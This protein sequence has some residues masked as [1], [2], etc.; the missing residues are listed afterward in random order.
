MHVSCICCVHDGS[1]C[2]LKGEGSSIQKINT[3]MPQ[4]LLPLEDPDHGGYDVPIIL[5][6]ILQD[7]MAHGRCLNNRIIW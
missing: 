6:L 7:T 3:F 5:S 2:N 1:V 4:S